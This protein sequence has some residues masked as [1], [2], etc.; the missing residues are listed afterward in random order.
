M[1][2]PRSGSWSIRSSTLRTLLERAGREN[3]ARVVRGVMAPQQRSAS[4]PATGCVERG[5][6]PRIRV[7]GLEGRDGCLSV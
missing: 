5:N 1:S 2:V 3:S 4:R 6:R 7:F